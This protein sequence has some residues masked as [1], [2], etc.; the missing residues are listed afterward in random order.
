[1]LLSK[2]YR[3]AERFSMSYAKV[4]LAMVVMVSVCFLKI[5]A[6]GPITAVSPAAAAQMPDTSPRLVLDAGGHR[7]I[8]RKLLFTADGRE[9]VSV[10]DDKTIRV[11]SVSPDGRKADLTRTIRGQIEDGRA[12]QL[13]AAALSP[14]DA[15]GRQQWLAVGGY[16]AGPPVDRDAIRLHDFASGEVRALLHGHTDNVLALAFSPSGRRLAS[17]G[18]D[19]T[20]RL[21]DL[22][23]LQ[24][25]RIGKTPLILKGHTDR[26]TGLTWSAEGDRLATASYDGTVGLWNST[27]LAQEKVHL[28]ARLKGH[29]GKVRSV[30]F[31]PDGI[32][33]ASG[34]QDR[35]IRLWQAGDGKSRGVLAGAEHQLSSLAFAPDGQLIVAGNFSPP[36][37]KHLTLFS[38]PAGKRHLLFG[39]HANLVIATAFHPSGLWL[40]SGGG[41]HKEILLWRATTVRYCH[42][43]RERVGQSMLSPFPR[44]GVLSV[45]D[46]PLTTPRSMIVDLS[47]TASI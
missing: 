3:Y 26:I 31:H 15:K 21:W 28:M 41:D 40:A 43:S 20:V 19:Q 27:Q 42:G 35:K 1:M 12:G 6:F 16:L 8:I 24:G 23:A 34:G 5:P 47:N 39:G 2:G 10:G 29:T 13:A 37:P 18:K 45:G 38:Y 30:A 36:K 4:S 44:T 32:V 17:A 9:L 46:R 14:P 11:W 7:A 33:L 22:S 25:Q